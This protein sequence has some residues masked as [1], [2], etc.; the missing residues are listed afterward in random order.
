[1]CK[2]DRLFMLLLLLGWTTA[3]VLVQ[4]QK[5][6]LV[7]GNGE[8]TTAAAPVVSKPA[9]LWV[10][11]SGE[12]ATRNLYFGSGGEKHQ[13]H[14]GFKFE[15]EDMNGTNPKFEVTDVDG[16]KWKV[17]L[18]IEARPETVATRLVWAAGYHVTDDYFL[19]EIH[20]DGLPH[21]KRGEHFVGA[22]GAI[23]NVRV[24]K[25]PGKK[26]DIWHWRD[27]PFTGT[28]ELNGLRVMMALINNWDLKDEN[29]AIF[30]AKHHKKKGENKTAD[31]TTVQTTDQSGEETNDEADMPIYLVTD[32][33]ASFGADRL[34]FPFAKSKDNLNAYR[35]SKFIRQV[36][37][38]YVDFG[39]P[40]R[41]APIYLLAKPHDFFTRP[42]LEWIGHQIP[43]ADVKWIG[44]V[45]AQLTPEQIHD[46]FRAGGYSPEE[47][48]AYSAIVQQRI[49]E[50][51]RL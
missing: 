35:H 22:D 46:A 36:T 9:S 15:K 10:D 4:A 7:A 41:P 37:A 44:Q 32:L 29:N 28:R 8:K 13:P 31:Q 12:L 40:E 23:H 6:H 3:S 30:E 1:M 24:K 14:P 51:N 43:R 16:V 21:L 11:P 49:A 25:N 47:I 45:L 26:I 2:R 38:E 39:T 5:K 17:K 18:G 20:V 50:L 27:N 19:P 34:A 48:E 42:Q 33:G